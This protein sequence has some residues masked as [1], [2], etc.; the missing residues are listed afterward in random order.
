MEELDAFVAFDMVLQQALRMRVVAEGREELGDWGVDLEVR[1]AVV[2]C[3]MEAGK[4]R[5]SQEAKGP[6]G[7]SVEVE[8]SSQVRK[9]AKDYIVAVVKIGVGI[10]RQVGQRMEVVD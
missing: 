1:Q 2:V 4:R 7:S 3:A 10:V 8:G 9:I 5:M 6:Q